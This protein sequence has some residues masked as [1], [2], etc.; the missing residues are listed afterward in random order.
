M[1]FAKPAMWMDVLVAKLDSLMYAQN[2]MIVKHIFLMDCAPVQMLLM[3]L[4]TDKGVQV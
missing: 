1:E 2:A 4:I 3:F